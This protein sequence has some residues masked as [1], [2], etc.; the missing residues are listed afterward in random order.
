[1]IRT[2]LLAAAALAALTASAHADP[3]TM[4]FHETPADTAPRSD[5]TEAG[6]AYWSVWVEYSAMLAQTGVVRGG[7]P[8]IVSEGDGTAISGYFILDTTLAEA[9]AL[10]A[11]APATTRDGRVVVVRHL[12]VP[13][14]SN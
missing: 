3:F 2:P 7:A 4:V 1:M 10:A 5:T 14:M 6:A 9:E 12:A 13:G 11:L 8:L